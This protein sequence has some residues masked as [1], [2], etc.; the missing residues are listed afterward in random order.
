[1]IIAA[2]WDKSL[3]RFP[4]MLA[5]HINQIPRHTNV[6]ICG[7]LTLVKLC[8]AFGMRRAPIPDLVSLTISGCILTGKFQTDP[9]PKSRMKETIH[10]TATPIGFAYPRPIP[11]ELIELPWKDERPDTFW[12]AFRYGFKK[13][14]ADRPWLLVIFAV[15][16]FLILRSLL[17][18]AT[19]RHYR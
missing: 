11:L 14:Y 3:R 7:Y 19:V 13:Y 10:V 2:H 12:A 5:S 17:R 6:P 16:G 15:F 4:W 1:M 9:L 8:K 18:P